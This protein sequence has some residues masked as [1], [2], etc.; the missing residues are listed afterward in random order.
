MDIIADVNQK[1]LCLDLTSQYEGLVQELY[2]D[3]RFLSAEF[4][5]KIKNSTPDLWILHQRLH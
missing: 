5:Q 3:F 4:K 2:D 1:I